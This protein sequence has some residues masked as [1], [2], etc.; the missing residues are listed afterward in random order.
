MERLF[1]RI[2]GLFIIGFLTAVLVSACAKNLD[3]NVTI[4]RLSDNCRV[5]QHTMGESCVP[6]DPQRIIALDMEAL[7]NLL[8]MDIKPIAASSGWDTE[9]PFPK[10]IQDKLDI[11]GNDIEYVGSTTQPN[12]EKMLSLKPDLILSNSHMENFYQQLSQIAPTLVMQHPNLWKEKLLDLAQKL[13]KED[14]AQELMTNYVQRIEELQETLLDKRSELTVSV[15]TMTQGG[16]VRTYA[17]QHA[18]SAVLSDLGVQRPPS[19]ILNRTG[20]IS[21]EKLDSVDGDVLFFVTRHKEEDNNAISRLQENPLWKKLQVVQSDQVYLV[22]LDH[23][24]LDNSILGIDAVIDDLFK[25]L[26][27]SP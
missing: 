20:Q 11:I 19:Q 25:Y 12:L 13:N 2:A 3:N 26:V 22:D 21:V 7:G 8:A 24:Y 18:I 15:I 4:E 1:H 17:S 14:V 16:G 10:H 23:W 27:N 6:V 5:V 9:E